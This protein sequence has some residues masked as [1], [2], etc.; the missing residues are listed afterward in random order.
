MAQRRTI[1]TRLLL[2]LA[3]ACVVLGSIEAWL[4]FISPVKFMRIEAPE[5]NARG[6]WYGLIH[7][8]SSVPGLAYELVPGLDRDVAGVRVA[9]NSLG[10]RDEEPLPRSTPGLFRIL[11]LGDSVAFGFRVPVESGFCTVLEQRLA[12]GAQESRRFE[13][14][15]TGVSGYSSRDEAAALDGKWLALEPDLILLCYCLND[16]EIEPR[17]PLQRHFA[18]TRWWQHSSTLRFL[19]NRW[20][21]RKQR[22]LGGGDYWRY[23]HAPTE[24]SWKSVQSAF[25][26]IASRAQE[27]KI[28]VVLAIFPMFG[29]A[30][31]KDY[32]YREQHAQVAAEGARNGFVVLDLLPRFE[33]EEPQSL[34]IALDDSHP[35][36]KGHAIAAEE[37][38]KILPVH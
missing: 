6:G 17:Q 32:P 5:A 10:M 31:W 13:V 23:L 9:T 22:T 33:Q 37:L 1:A 27:R 18:P 29:P 19:V 34:L 3:C 4:T 14:L 20:E 15:D 25:A 24:P 11:A 38:A 8:P 12:T 30:A 36:A 28:P 21:G 26:R 7:Q 2:T 35:N 16:P